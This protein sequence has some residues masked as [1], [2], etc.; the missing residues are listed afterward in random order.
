MYTTA[1]QLL[2]LFGDLEMAQLAAPKSSAVDGVLLR[3][4]LENGDRSAYSA[5]DIAAADAAEVRLDNIVAEASLEADSYLAPR[6]ALPLSQALINGSALPRKTAD[7][8]RYL[9]MDNRSTEEIEKRYN[10]AIKWL[11]DISMNKASLGE[12]DTGV[13]SQP[14][15]MVARQG[16]SGT[17]WST[18]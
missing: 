16:V 11:R 3:L 4:T 1:L 14:G 2:D 12:Q 17:D 6:Y 7:I 13:T 5:A 8:A 18:F 9:L 15:R 10:S